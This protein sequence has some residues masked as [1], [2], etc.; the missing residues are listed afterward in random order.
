MNASFWHFTS[1]LLHCIIRQDYH[2]SENL[3]YG[4]LISV[5]SVAGGLTHSSPGALTLQEI[6]EGRMLG[7]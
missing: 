1:Q 3:N 4:L 7:T 5:N 2:S 6:R